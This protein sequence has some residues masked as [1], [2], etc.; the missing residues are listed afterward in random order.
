MRKSLG[1]L[2]I[3]AAALAA[4]LLLTGCSAGTV[5]GPRGGFFTAKNGNKKESDPESESP[6]AETDL[7]NFSAD[8]SKDRSNARKIRFDDGVLTIFGD[9]GELGIKEVLTDF[10]ADVE[11]SRNGSSFTCTV[12]Y[13]SSGSRYG[14][15]EIVNSRY[16][17]TSFRVRLSHG[18]ISMPNVIANAQSNF[19]LAQADIPK[20]KAAVTLANITSS[21]DKTRVA[22]ILAE[23]KELSDKICRGLTN[24]YDKLRA[25]SRWVSAN[26]Y[27][28][29][30]AFNAG[31]P[32]KCLTLEYILENRS[33]VCGSY[34]NITAALCQAQG[35]ICYNV[36][37]EGLNSGGCYAEQSRGNAHEWNYAYIAGRGIWVDS[38]WNS[39]NHLYDYGITSEGEIGCKYFDVGNEI[40]AL[41]HKV[42]S[43][44]NRD[45]FDPDLLV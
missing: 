5:D 33:G 45:F 15:V 1:A 20:D 29:H 38:G 27:Y 6:G 24:E 35:I 28:D 16:Q 34:A 23:V 43:L 12:T 30:P 32:Q 21:G 18:A 11:L 42:Y 44:S 41:D 17:S 19:E 8:L 25:I 31:I 13:T 2:K 4:V 7:L 9:T 39:Y 40:L 26:I 14:I 36:N 37:G 10:P 22:E 3:C